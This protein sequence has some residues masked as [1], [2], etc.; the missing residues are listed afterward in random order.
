MK[1]S[2]DSIYVR[3]VGVDGLRLTVSSTHPGDFREIGDPPIKIENIEIEGRGIGEAGV[4]AAPNMSSPRLVFT[5]KDGQNLQR[6][7]L[8]KRYK[9]T[10]C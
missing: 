9:L 5:A 2:I 7:E 4:P 1:K 10:S 6:L 3:L 8:N